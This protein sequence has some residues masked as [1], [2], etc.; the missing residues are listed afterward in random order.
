MKNLKTL[1]FTKEHLSGLI[2]RLTLGLVILPHGCQLLLGWFGGYGF[3]GSMNYFTNDAG[4]PWIIGFLVIL[5]QFFGALLLIAGVATRLMAFAMLGLFTGMILSTHLDHGFFMNWYG[6]KNGEGFEY[7][8]L[9]IGLALCLL[10][11][12]AGKLSIDG[13]ITRKLSPA[14]N[15]QKTNVYE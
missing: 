10:V 5:L 14:Y 12:G 7:H 4:L 13:F 3:T 6:N 8:L 2:S 15:I 9:V 1:L 11:T